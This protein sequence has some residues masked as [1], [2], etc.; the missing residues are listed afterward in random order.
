MHWTHI[1]AKCAPPKQSARVDARVQTSC[2]ELIHLRIIQQ[3]APFCVG[4]EEIAKGGTEK[5]KTIISKAKT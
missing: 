3:L 4:F 5:N 1:H 2:G